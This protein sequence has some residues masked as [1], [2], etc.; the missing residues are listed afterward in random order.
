MGNEFRDPAYLWDMLDAARSIARF[1]AGISLDD[2]L[3]NEMMELAVERQLEIMGEAARRISDTFKK[4][5]SEIPWRQ[6]IG[7]RNILIHEYGEILEDRIWET[8]NTD[9]PALIL[10]LELLIPPLPPEK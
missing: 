10:K 6:I 3:K 5:H 9:I 1:T 4:E 7:Q 2:F 8:V